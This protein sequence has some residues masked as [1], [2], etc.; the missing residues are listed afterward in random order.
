M[1][2]RSGLIVVALLAI[3]LAEYG[4]RE[5]QTNRIFARLNDDNNNDTKREIV[6]LLIAGC[7]KKETYSIMP[8]YI[9]ERVFGR[10]RSFTQA[11]LSGVDFSELNL[12]GT[13]FIDTDF[14][15]A[16]FYNAKLTGTDMSQSNLSGADIRFATFTDANLRRV[17]LSEATL[18]HGLYRNTDFSSANFSGARL[19]QARIADSD[20]SN[21]NFSNAFVYKSSFFSTRLNSANLSDATFSEDHLGSASLTNVNL[22]NTLFLSTLLRP[23]KTLTKNQLERENPPLICNSPLPQPMNSQ[24]S[25]YRDCNNL[26]QILQQRHPEEFPSREEVNIHFEAAICDSFVSRNVE[27]AGYEPITCSEQS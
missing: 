25:E 24:V 5:T 11:Q 1:K 21:A 16:N 10:C 14:S 13:T 26:A 6:Q 27:M 23:N 3:A 22:S 12:S 8:H 15:G 2:K 9:A 4:I 7:P 18:Y 17:N 20:F 19:I